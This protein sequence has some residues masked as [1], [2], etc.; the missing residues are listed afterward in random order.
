MSAPPF[1]PALLQLRP[2]E[3]CYAPLVARWLSDPQER[4][5]VSP[6]SSAPVTAAQV[7][8]WTQRDGAALMLFAGDDVLPCGYAELNRLRGNAQDLWIGHLIVDPTQRGRGCGSTFVRLLASRAFG[9]L[10]ATRVALVV[11]PQNRSA[12][13][14]Y[15]RC[16]FCIVGDEY[17]TFATRP[18]A[19]RMLRLELRMPRGAGRLAASAAQELQVTQPKPRG[20]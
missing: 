3:A 11:F 4:F 18:Q 13:R 5:W 8:T 2:F 17:H 9:S 20:L 14:C 1:D 7:I 6:S 15:Q 10:G 19:Y 12:L 16:G